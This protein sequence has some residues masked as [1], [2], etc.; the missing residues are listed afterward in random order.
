MG[1]RPRGLSDSM[2]SHEPAVQRLGALP[3]WTERNTLARLLAGEPAGPDELWA[4]VEA[5]R[6]RNNQGR[7]THRA[8]R[9]DLLAVA[10]AT[11]P[12]IAAPAATVRSQ[13]RWMGPRSQSGGISRETR[14]RV[15]TRS[16]TRHDAAHRAELHRLSR[17]R[18]VP[19][20]T[21]VTHVCTPIDISTSVVEEGGLVFSP[22]VLRLRDHPSSN[23]RTGISNRRREF[24]RRRLCL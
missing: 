14:P 1:D 13:G 20:L 21:L 6:R 12:V 11:L 4:R 17:R 18:A 15:Q 3:S 5:V 23:L 16:E 7:G 2:P 10:P 8:S 24:P 9:V 22:A 19:C